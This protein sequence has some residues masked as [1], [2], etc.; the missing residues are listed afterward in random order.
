MNKPTNYWIQ[1]LGSSLLLTAFT[2]LFALLSLNSA[3]AAKTIAEISA[4][5][6]AKLV[7]QELSLVAP[8]L[9]KKRVADLRT[10][11]DLMHQSPHAVSSDPRTPAGKVASGELPM[12]C[13]A[14]HGEN[15]QH[16]FNVGVDVPASVVNETCLSCHSGGDRMH[17]SG[18]PHEM[19]NMA[20]VNCHSMHSKNE[21]LL[22]TDNQLELC[23][24]CHQERRA[25]FNRP[26]HHPVK[27]GQV[28]CTDCHN[29]HGTAGP[30]L[31]RGGDV[32]ETCYTCHAEMRGPFLWDHQ[33]VREAC[34]NCH[35]PHGSVNPAMLEA[36][37]AQLC[38]S[39]HVTDSTHP[40]D[41]M[42]GDTN[43]GQFKDPMLGGKQC[44]NCHT[45]VHGSNHPGGAFF[46]K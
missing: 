40:G 7:E 22:R 5:E 31:L 9:A 20:C 10:H 41:L 16:F 27:E 34:I 1:R 6:R 44:L 36:R 24:S 29:P 8:L 28:D 15:F 32:N 4:E 30:R 13:F 25:D 17:W 3:Q 38:Q 46:R 21:R 39:C 37:P 2:L 35:N 12:L 26:Y 19:G 33:P 18:G 42:S 23:S 14:C 45:Q 11:I 43:Q